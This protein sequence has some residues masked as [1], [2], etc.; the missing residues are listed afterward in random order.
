[1]NENSGA[2]K[3]EQV[4]DS[5][6]QRK[7]YAVHVTAGSEKKAMEQLQSHIEASELR[8][9]FGEVLLPIEIVQEFR[10]GKRVDSQH[11]LYPSYLFVNMEMTPDTWHLVRNTPKIHGFIGGDSRDPRPMS[12]L[13]VEDIRKRVAEG[14]EKPRPKIMFGIGERIRIKEGPFKDFYGDIEDINYERNK[15]KI[16]VVVL[17]RATSVELDFGHIEKA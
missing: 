13:E 9:Q 14:A 8:G 16:S 12:D 10:G 4:S 15:L 11:K 3:A 5:M 6:G 2:W 7:W 17:G 1:M